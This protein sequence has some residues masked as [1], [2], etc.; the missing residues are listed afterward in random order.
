MSNQPSN[1]V[2]SQTN[3]DLYV[4]VFVSNYTLIY[5]HVSIHMYNNNE[6]WVVSINAINF[7]LL[8]NNL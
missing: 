3:I 4:C 2:H 1:K 6:V 8:W 7:N 5:V